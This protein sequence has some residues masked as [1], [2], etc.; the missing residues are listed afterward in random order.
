MKLTRFCLG[1]LVF[2]V[3]LAAIY[4]AHINFLPVNVIFYSAMI[5]AVIATIAAGLIIC[6]LRFF[7]PLGGFEKFQLIVIFVL[8]GYAFAISGPTVID[9]SL[10]FYILE[11]LQQRGG[12]IREDAIGTVFVNEY[13]PE[14]RLVDV[15]LTEQ[16]ESGTITI[17]NGCVKLTPKGER[18]ASL[19]QFLRTHFLAKKRLLAGE[20]TD[21]LVDPFRNSKGGEMG[22]ECN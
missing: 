2:V 5:D 15:R 18:L 6:T 1:C 11:K 7:S 12:G 9:R 8:G 10:S 13:M 16:L 19:G 20:Y 17:E 3:L 4:L 14:Y 21:A 22:Y